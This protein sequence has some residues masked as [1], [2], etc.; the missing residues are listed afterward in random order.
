MADGTEP[1]AYCIP[2]VHPIRLLLQKIMHITIRDATS[3]AHPAELEDAC[4]TA[5][6]IAPPIHPQLGLQKTHA[7]AIAMSARRWLKHL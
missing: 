2:K 1:R 3:A 7:A 4:S 6:A 5:R